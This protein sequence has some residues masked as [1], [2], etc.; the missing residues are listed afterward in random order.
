MYF[1]PLIYLIAFLLN[2]WA[3]AK[4]K[5]NVLLIAVDDLNADLG[6]YGHPLVKSPNV[7]RLSKRG[8]RFDKAYCQYPVCNPSRSSFM[9][10]LYPE[11]TGVSFQTLVT[12]EIRTQIL[13]RYPNISLTT[14][15]SPPASEKSIIT[16][17]LFKSALTG[18]MIKHP[19]TK[20]LTQLG[21][22]E[23]D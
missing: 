22:I 21:L 8:L 20:S 13:L 5:P 2:V 18:W 7:D 19:G 15:T 14:A 6:C 16:A 23:L 12:F 1:R 4:E 10:G 3:Q 11:Q 17:S 9:T